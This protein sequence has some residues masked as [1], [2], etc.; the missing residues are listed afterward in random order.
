MKPNSTIAI[1]GAGVAGLTAAQ[2][3]REYGYRGEVRLISREPDPLYDRPALSKAFLLAESGVEPARPVSGDELHR[4]DIRLDTGVAISE[5]DRG[6]RTLRSSHGE[7][8]RYDALLLACG[9]QPRRLEVPDTGLRG[10][11]YLRELSDAR[12]LR[13]KL[14]PG[15]RLVVVGGGVIGLEVAASATERGANVTI[16]EAAAHMMGRVVPAPMAEILEEIHAQ[17]GVAIKTKATTVAF[18]HMNGSV[19]GVRLA[20]GAVLPADVVLIGVG[21][22]PVT[23]LARQSGLEVD[24][25]VVVDE[26]FRTSDENIYAAGDAA[27]VFDA[28]AGHHVR[29]EQWQVARDQGQFA[30]A[31]MLG[32]RD[33]YRPTPW[34]WSD[35]YDLHIQAT[36]AGF[37]GTELIPR[38]RLEDR[39]GVVYFGV[40]QRHVVAACGVAL[41]TGISRTIR[42]AQTLIDTGLEVDP[43]ELADPELD[44]RR[45]VRASI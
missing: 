23:E 31:S 19:S 17:R 26:Y 4:S 32:A 1:V 15:C 16:V 42:A 11:H 37:E 9:A 45:L 14:L 39:S 29:Y 3:L 18:E 27:R 12:L 6:N 7:L 41:G 24:N 40:R 36:G 21:S 20:D 44:L 10:I 34:M 13:D 30:A 43:Y 38:G 5:V 2:A 28:R 25:G 33:P 35:Q 22:T 8:V